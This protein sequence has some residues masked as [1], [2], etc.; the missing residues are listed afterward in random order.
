MRTAKRL[1]SIAV[2]AVLVIGVAAIPGAAPAT[3]APALLSKQATTAA[4]LKAQIDLQMKL[5]PGGTRVGDNEVSYDGG[6]FVVTYAKPG[7]A[8]A[9]APDCPSN[10]QCFYDRV[11]FG[12][13]RGK[14]SDPIWEDLSQY[15]W[16]DRA[17]SLHNNTNGYAVLYQNHRAGRTDHNDDHYVTCLPSSSWMPNLVGDRN[18][19]DH[20]YTHIDESGSC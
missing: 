20:T 16:H 7:A 12:Y 14:L 8:R 10:W 13:P 17:E 11:D 3:A 18:K 19:I 9:L 15:G 1:S 6:R 4:E 2:A 5:Y